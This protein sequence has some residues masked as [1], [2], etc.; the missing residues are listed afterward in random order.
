MQDE[1]IVWHEMMTSK[2]RAWLL[3]YIGFI[4]MLKRKYSQGSGAVCVLSSTAA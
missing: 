3:G 1:G 2:K 4:G